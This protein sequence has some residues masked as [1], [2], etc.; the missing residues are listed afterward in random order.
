MIFALKFF[1]TVTIRWL[2]CVCCL[3]WGDHGLKD[4][5]GD[6]P[7][8]PSVL[9]EQSQPV[10]IFLYNTDKIK[11]TEHADTNFKL[12]KINPLFISHSY[13]ASNTI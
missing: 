3:E 6:V 9:Q 12:R 4:N 2:Y 7:R 8:V 13:K 10:E 1:Y 5:G 11:F